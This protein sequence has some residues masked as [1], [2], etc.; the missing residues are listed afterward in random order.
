[1]ELGERKD[2]NVPFDVEV[3]SA[4][5]YVEVFAKDADEAWALAEAEGY[6]PFKVVAYG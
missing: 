5:G 1:M 3:R 2:G 4:V 6:S